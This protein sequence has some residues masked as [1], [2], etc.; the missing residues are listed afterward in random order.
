[1]KIF[2]QALLLKMVWQL[3]SNSDKLWVQIFKAKYFS[4]AGFWAIKNKRDASPLWRAIQD[5]KHI[6]MDQIGWHVG[7]GTAIKALNEPWYTGCV[8]NHI[9][10]NAQ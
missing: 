4:K 9:T 3:A 6:L 2:N 5:L 8:I 1:M 10:T 7:Q